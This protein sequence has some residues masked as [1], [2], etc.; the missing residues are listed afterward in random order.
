MDHR[1]ASARR[2]GRA[3][4]AALAAVGMGAALIVAPAVLAAAETRRKENASQ[5]RRSDAGA[6]PAARAAASP[7]SPGSGHG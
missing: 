6:R 3:L 5:A 2:C 7:S 1:I 4:T